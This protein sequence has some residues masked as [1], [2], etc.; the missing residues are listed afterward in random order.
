M[1]YFV[2]GGAGFIGS[3]IVNTLIKE[4][5]EVIVLDDL[6][7]GD[8]QN[9]KQSKNLTFVKGD[10]RDKEMIKE[11][12][13][14]NTFSFIFHLAAIASVADSIE[15]C[16]RDRFI[17]GDGPLKNEMRQLILSLDLEKNVF[18]LGHQENPFTI[19]KQCDLFVFPSIYEG[20]P[21]VLLEALTLKLPVLATN[22]PA[23]L[24]VLK[25]YASEY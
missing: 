8:L 11:I 23:N 19:M 3:T 6:S 13:E 12:F 16:I 2:S 15:M 5:N 14:K 20:Q 25:N 18:L 21:M 4:G 17:I 7:M 1:K 9:L 24:S 22:I 10:I